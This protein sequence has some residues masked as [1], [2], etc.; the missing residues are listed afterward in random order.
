M[1][2]FDPYIAKFT[3]QSRMKIRDTP[4]AK[5]WVERR[6]GSVGIFDVD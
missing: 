1:R 5:P 3:H 2:G 6:E 4:L